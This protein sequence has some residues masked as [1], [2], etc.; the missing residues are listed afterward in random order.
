MNLS[1]LIT[2]HALLKS[3]V[4]N[5]SLL[6]S[7]EIFFSRL[8]LDLTGFD[9]ELAKSLDNGQVTVNLAKDD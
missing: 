4:K 5:R 3:S 6:R 1:K 7:K 2:I 8:I 9:I